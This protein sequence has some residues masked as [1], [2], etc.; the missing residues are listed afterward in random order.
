MSMIWRS[1]S[2]K[3]CSG[4]SLNSPLKTVEDTN[5]PEDEPTIEDSQFGLS[6]ISSDLHLRIDPVTFTSARP[7]NH[8]LY[9]LVWSSVRA[10]YG[11]R[12]GKVRIAEEAYVGSVEEIPNETEQIEPEKR[13]EKAEELN[14]DKKDKGEIAPD[15]ERTSE[16]GVGCDS[17][18]KSKNNFPTS[19]N[20]WHTYDNQQSPSNAGDWQ[21]YSQ[22]QQYWGYMT[23]YGQQQQW[24]NMDANQQ[25]QWI[26]WWQVSFV[27]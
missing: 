7:I 9:A 10:N 16:S 17:Y 5:S 24:Q 2:P 20:K 3:H 12:K 1:R 11:V 22:Q 18:Q 15:D 4:G 23:D 19:N 26:S 27:V 6:W 13:K 8:D 25:Q 14:E 21:Q